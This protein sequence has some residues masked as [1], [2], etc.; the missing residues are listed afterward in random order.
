MVGDHQR[1]SLSS[2]QE[3]LDAIQE[4]IV[5]ARVIDPIETIQHV[6]LVVAEHIGGEME[7]VMHSFPR[8]M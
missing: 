8:D 7:K 6:L 5:A 2:G 3:F 4:K 1:Y